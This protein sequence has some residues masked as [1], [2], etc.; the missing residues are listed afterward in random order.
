MTKEIAIKHIKD[1]NEQ[2]RFQE[3]L[4]E[5]LK[6]TRT[7]SR[8]RTGDVRR[9]NDLINGRFDL[10]RVVTI[11]RKDD[12]DSI[13]NKWADYTSE[14]IDMLIREGEDFERRAI[15]KITPPNL[16]LV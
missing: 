8:K 12:A 3:D 14:T 16:A 11:E 6:K 1:Q 13:S 9:Y 15:V 2:K 10:K 5:Y 4:T 7:E